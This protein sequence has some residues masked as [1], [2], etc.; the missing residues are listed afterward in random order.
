MKPKLENVPLTSLSTTPNNSF[1]P[2][3]LIGILFFVF[4]FVT[5]LNGALIPFL[6][7]ACELNEFEAY[8]VTFVFYIAYFVMALPTSS[9]LTKVGYKMGMTLG[10]GTMAAG[11]GLFILAALVSHFASFLFALFV[12]GTGLTVLQTAA[13]PYIVCI[14]PRESA[15]M[16]ISLM[17]IVNKGAGFIVPILFTAWILTG[18][19]PY[20]EQALASLTDVQREIAL[21]EL[22]NRLVLPYL[23][24]AIVLVGLMLFVFYSPLPEPDLGEKVQSSNADWKAILK[25]RQVILGALTL[26]CYIGVEVIAGDSIGLFSQ[27]LG[28]AHFGMMTSYTMGFMVIGYVLG[29]LL[30]PRVISQ[31]TALTGSALAG[32]G[33]TLGILFSDSQ[34]QTVSQFLLGWLGVLPVPDPVLY[35][36]LLGLANA[37]VWPAVWPLALQGLGR[38]TATASALLIMGIAGGAILPLLYGYIAHSQG[39]SQMA[40]FLLLP[41][42]AMIFYYAVWG[43]KT[44][45]KETQP[46][47]VA[48]NE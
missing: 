40:Y 20:S 43:H 33:F 36:A 9:I 39:D 46:D 35:L 12:L 21:A 16:R 29:I 26:F 25:Y 30:I 4:G 17:G 22:S 28:V 14:G 3:L 27:G 45:A 5:W 19:E 47:V 41:C 38:L 23:L 6:K 8:L 34:S 1:I 24:M 10:L 42:Y 32:L 11:A 37:L 2:M 48:L 44:T 15:A 18:M 31:Q 7:I 13:N